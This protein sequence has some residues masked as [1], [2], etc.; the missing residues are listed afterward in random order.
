M[1]TIRYM[2]L[3]LNLKP[4]T[5]FRCS[6]RS[7]QIKDNSQI[8]DMKIFDIAI[9]DIIIFGISISVHKNHPNQHAARWISKNWHWQNILI[10]AFVNQNMTAKFNWWWQFP[11]MWKTKY[12][13][14]VQRRGIKRKYK[15]QNNSLGRSIASLYIS[16]SKIN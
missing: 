12:S 5:K 7:N 14:S 8:F 16:W 9:S 15:Y 10:F 1:L 11:K 6:T 2:Y 4:L 13:I 3:N